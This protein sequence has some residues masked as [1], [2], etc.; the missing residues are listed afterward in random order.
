MKKL[1][2]VKLK[3]SEPYKSH[4][5]IDDMHGIVVDVIHENAEVL[6]FN[7]HNVGDYT[8]VNVKT[9]DLDLDKE[10]LPIEI[11]KELLSKLDTVKSK[12][13]NILEPIAINEYDMVELLVEEER[14]AKFGIHKGDIGCVMDNNAV[15]NYI[16]VDFSGIDK[17]GN[18]YGDCISVKI[19][20]L[21]VIK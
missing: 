11:E 12:A 15:Q 3:N 1:D 21:K 20:H 8:I 18:Y 19:D 14:Y 10:K 13:K 17:D 4:N 6:F 5:V 2:L 7:P 9:T 16:E